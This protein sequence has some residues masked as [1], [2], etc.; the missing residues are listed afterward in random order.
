M[1]LETLIG[2]VVEDKSVDGIYETN[3]FLN[4]EMDILTDDRLQIVIS[5]MEKK[6]IFDSIRKMYERLTMSG[7]VKAR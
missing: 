6:T 2:R 4:F 7:K 5:S 1:E 3:G